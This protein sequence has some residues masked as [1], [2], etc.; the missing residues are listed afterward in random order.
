MTYQQ[1]GLLWGFLTDQSPESFP[2][3]I[4]SRGRRV[5]PLCVGWGSRHT[6]LHP[7]I[8]GDTLQ[9]TMIPAPRARPELT[10]RKPGG[11]R[12]G[13]RRGLCGGQRERRGGRPPLRAA[14]ARPRQ[15]PGPEGP[16]S[17]G[18]VVA[19]STATNEW[20]RARKVILAQNVGGAWVVWN[21]E[22]SE[23]LRLQQVCSSPGMTRSLT[24]GSGTS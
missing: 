24:Q 23:G 1:F 9:Q 11:D 12:P 6:P 19:R 8:P 4:W 10:H 5:P 15:C 7:C 22:K 14:A 17:A 20:D 3:P 16:R 21:V 2:D 13:P 18:Y